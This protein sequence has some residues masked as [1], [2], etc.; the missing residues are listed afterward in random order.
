MKTQNFG[1]SRLRF[2]FGDGGFLTYSRLYVLALKDYIKNRENG[3]EIDNPDR[4]FPASGLEQRDDLGKEFHLGMD[5]AYDCP[6][7]DSQGNRARCWTTLKRKQPDDPYSYILECIRSNKPVSRELYQSFRD[8]EPFEDEQSAEPI[9]GFYDEPDYEMGDPNNDENRWRKVV[10]TDA[11]NDKIRKWL[12]EKDENYL[13]RL[14]RVDPKLHEEEVKNHPK[15]PPVVRH[16]AK[17][18]KLAKIQQASRQAQLHQQ[19]IDR[20]QQALDAIQLARWQSSANSGVSSSSSNSRTNSSSGSGDPSA[21]S[22]RSSSSN[23]SSGHGSFGRFFAKTEKAPLPKSSGKRKVVIAKESYKAR[24]EKQLPFSEGDKLTVIDKNG[25]GWWC[26]ERDDGQRGLVLPNYLK[27]V[28]TPLP[29]FSIVRRIY[30][31]YRL[32]IPINS[33]TLTTSTAATLTGV[34]DFNHFI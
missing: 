6:T 10:F 11:R 33:N 7:E 18:A 5:K 19:R 32:Q 17:L 30:Q 14:L 26:C 9:T 20:L 16:L 13:E 24:K 29:G 15:H 3:L 23:T 28:E 8:A 27:P 12:E 31:I 25:G 21:S 1:S 34:F 4:P 22:N 2:R